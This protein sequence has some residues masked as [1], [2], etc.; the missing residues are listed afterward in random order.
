ML[1]I[2][3]SF[4]HKIFVFFRLWVWIILD[5]GRNTHFS[6]RTGPLCSSLEFVIEFCVFFSILVLVKNHSEFFFPFSYRRNGAPLPTSVEN[7]TPPSPLEH[8]G[9][10]RVVSAWTKLVCH[11][12]D[13]R[14]SFPPS[15]PYGSL[16]RKRN[17]RVSTMTP[18]CE[19]GSILVDY[20]TPGFFCT[21]FS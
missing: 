18:S 13:T 4:T 21:G 6:L 20:S 2:F 8:S 1:C 9:S 3:L 17:P 14:V 5:G 16:G 7:L 10:V 19:A 11:C 15:G 12:W